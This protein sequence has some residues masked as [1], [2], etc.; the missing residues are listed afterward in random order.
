MRIILYTG[1]GG[2]GKT[3]ISAATAIKCAQLGHQTLVLS[4]DSAHS[5]GDSLEMEIGNGVAKVADNLYAEEI[6]VN[7]ELKVNWG[8]IQ[9]FITEFLHRRGFDDFIAEEFAI[10]PGMEELF[11]ILKLKEY[12]EQGR[13]DVAIIDCAPTGSTA[14]MLSFPDII[15]WYMERFFHLQRKIVKA[16]R[17]IAERIAK[18]PLPS[19]EVYFSLEELYQKIDGMKEILTNPEYS[20]V[21]I[22]FNPE[23]MVIKES[24]RIL[25][26]L[27][28]FNFPVDAAIANRLI[29]DAVDNSFFSQWKDI[30][31]QY[32]RLAEESFN[33]LPIFKVHL[34]H[35][36]MVGREML[37]QMADE[38][39][40]DKDPSTI[41]FKKRSMTVQKVN[42]DYLLTIPLP[43][44]DKKDLDLWVR[45]D[46]LIITMKNY[47]RNLLLPRTISALPLKEARF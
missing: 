37:Q 44:S 41:F 7:Y 31:T 33:P 27:N 46:E 8:K 36:E 16:I 32:M 14:R 35:R 39:F 15:E 17:P 45:G 13:F 28:L 29:P 26:Y 34:F 42:N 6:N 18:V 43:H 25:T 10:F 11:S 4:T 2:V 5:L 1:K 22:V 3:S 19:D 20:S 23:K 40:E 30:E 38:I 47:R 9:S 12:E 21:R 24:Q